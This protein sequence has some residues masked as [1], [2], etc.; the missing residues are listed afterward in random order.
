MSRSYRKNPAGGNTKAE[1]DRA[2]KRL[3]NRR[4]RAKVHQRL[5]VL[6]EDEVDALVLPRLREVSNFW[7][8]PK[9]GHSYYGAH[10]EK[11]PVWLR[12]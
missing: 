8:F 7:D 5:R 6:A 2:G 9:D 12:K 11:S 1:S 3:A 10:H 4:Y